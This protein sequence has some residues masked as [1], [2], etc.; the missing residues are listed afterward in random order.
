MKCFKSN[1]LAYFEEIEKDLPEKK[2]GP[3]VFRGYPKVWWPQ[4]KALLMPHVGEFWRLK[5]MGGNVA[6]GELNYLENMPEQLF[7]INKSV[8][9]KSLWHFGAAE[10]AIDVDTKTVEIRKAIFRK[11][12]FEEIDRELPERGPEV[13]EIAGG[14]DTWEKVRD[15]LLPHCGEVW[16]FKRRGDSGPSI[17]KLFHRHEDSEYYESFH[18]L[19]DNGGTT[20]MLGSNTCAGPNTFTGPNTFIR[21]DTGHKTI[22]IDY[23]S[24]RKAYF[25]EIDRELPEPGPE[26]V[27]FRGAPQIWW[28]KAKDLLMPHVGE[29]GWRIFFVGGD[30]REGELIYRPMVRPFPEIFNIGTYH[31]AQADWSLTGCSLFI[32]VT[33]KTVEM[34]YQFSN[35]KTIKAYFEEVE[36]ELPKQHWKWIGPEDISRELFQKI[37]D[38]YV[39]QEFTLSEDFFKK[40]HRK[41]RGL[42]TKH[43]SPYSGLEYYM[44][45]EAGHSSIHFRVG[46]G[47]T[48]EIDLKPLETDKSLYVQQ[49]HG[50]S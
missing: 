37:L 19:L 25:E 47:V 29:K 50:E 9:A 24:I 10:L 23:D 4:A 36:D 12:Y 16:E 15:L 5:E 1:R 8:A 42:L 48:L 31:A 22:A 28:P 49:P 18:L 27:E 14:P 39:G 20:D 6:V 2:Q 44:V 35:P 45:G 41:Y 34:R 11:A 7:L 40:S 17:G 3:V 43:K 38:P 32:D 30:S 33:A 13:L 26:V 46:E 21:I